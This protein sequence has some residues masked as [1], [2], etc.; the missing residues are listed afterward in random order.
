[1]TDP[2]VAGVR[3]LAISPSEGEKPINLT[4][5]ESPFPKRNQQF[6]SHDYTADKLVGAVRRFL[7]RASWFPKDHPAI[8]AS[9][10]L[11]P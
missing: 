2:V 7:V 11:T 5:E 3:T 6:W 10:E 8:L 1:M 4:Y 9:E